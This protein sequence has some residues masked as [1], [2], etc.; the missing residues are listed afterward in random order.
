M[1]PKSS[2]GA[3]PVAS[4]SQL[5]LTSLRLTPDKMDQHIH[6]GSND[7]FVTPRRVRKRLTDRLD[8]P[9]GDSILPLSSPGS[10]KKIQL[11][12]GLT[13]KRPLTPRSSTLATVDLA[14]VHTPPR[15]SKPVDARSRVT[16]AKE[17]SHLSDMV[18]EL[19]DLSAPQRSHSQ[20][21]IPPIAVRL[22]K[23]DAT[24]DP[25]PNDS[26]D[27]SPATAV[28]SIHEL[29]QAGINNRFERDLET[30]F[31]DI[32]PPSSPSKASRIQALLQLIQKLKDPSF[33][34]QFV[35]VGMTR[36]L[37]RCALMDT[38][39]DIASAVL[40]TLSLSSLLSLDHVSLEHLLTAFK[41]IVHLS[42][43]LL[44][45]DQS[46]TKVV[47]DRRQNLSKALIRDL[48]E[49]S[50]EMKVG[51][52][53]EAI[54]ST[55]Q[56]VTLFALEYSLRNIRGQKTIPA[57]LPVALFNQLLSLLST[58]CENTASQ[59]ENQ[60][61]T[62]TLSILE[63][64]AVSRASQTREGQKDTALDHRLLGAAVTRLMNR[65]TSEHVGV[66]S[67]ALRL[68]VSL[69]NNEPVVCTA[70]AET[71]LIPAVFFVVK[72]D[73]PSLSDSADSGDEF[74]N[75]K[76][77]SVIMALG[78]LLNL[79]DCS[80]EARKRMYTSSTLDSSN[81]Q[82]LVSVFNDRAGKAAE[83]RTF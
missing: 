48:V 59:N 29:R 72:Q 58:L 71:D 44:I 32:E 45:N 4:P 65:T 82:W 2:A 12:E 6:L 35:E 34:R 5:G 46:F 18:D 67:I 28:K 40:L 23:P 17:R 9:E 57:D 24:A 42:P 77:D 38:D 1:P 27:A 20:A 69:T 54:S 47:R 33:A 39:T 8:A 15:I 74:N 62:A 37:A 3:Q 25:D 7:D 21:V 26:D 73:L 80:S 30:L 14:D 11:G 81:V 70:L 83:V 78:C 10:E 41:A 51:D 79:A 49:F 75:S 61:I 60:V 36:R 53:R 22:F 13:T 31:E 43:S 16:Y 63:Y 52:R 56:H 19:E 66:K 68:I 55:P 64:S 76:L 50:R